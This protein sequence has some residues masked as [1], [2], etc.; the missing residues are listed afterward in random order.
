MPLFMIQK[1]EPLRI[2]SISL[3]KSL[4]VFVDSFFVVFIW[5]K[6]YGLILVNLYIRFRGQSK[7]AILMAV[8][9][10]KIVWVINSLPQ[11]K[12]INDVL[13]INV[14]NMRLKF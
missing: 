3:G 12:K 13:T 5:L 10:N 14:Q 7:G 6:I 8:L 11:G 2:D 4:K 1:K 9:C